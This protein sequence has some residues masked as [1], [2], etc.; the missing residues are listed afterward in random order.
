MQSCYYGSVNRWECDENDHLN[1]RFYAEKVYQALDVFLR[2]CAGEADSLPHLATQHIRF[3]AEARMATPLRVDCGLLS[4]G[5]GGWEVVSL[6]VNQQ[7]GAPLAGFISR[8]ARHGLD[9]EAAPT[10]ETAPEWASPKGIDPLAAFTPPADLAGAFRAGFQTM[11]RGVI[12]TAECDR[13]GALLPHVYIG[14]LSDG[15][16]NLWAFTADEETA[17]GRG[18]GSHG[19]AALEYRL[20]VHRPLRAGDVFRHVSGIRAIGNKTQHMVHLLWNETR[21]EVAATAEAIGVAMD[22]ATRRAIPVSDARRRALE[23]LLLR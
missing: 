4:A 10:F 12:S 16:P 5:D 7:S 13:T 20:A 2:E 9:V 17:S 22:L 8:V 19:G 15:M 21:D 23:K 3:V 6:M 18:A 14:R 11:G 1:V